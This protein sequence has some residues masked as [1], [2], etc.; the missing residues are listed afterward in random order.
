MNFS[1]W[2][3]RTALVMAAVFGLLHLLGGRQHVGMLSGTLEGGLAGLIFGV[4]YTLSWFTTVLLVPVL[5][6]A[7]LATA[8]LHRVRLV[9][10][11]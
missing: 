9:K 2:M 5:L 10:R 11:R 4:L 3:L 8:A 7:G 1:N 6:L